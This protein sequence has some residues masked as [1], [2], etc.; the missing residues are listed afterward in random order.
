[1]NYFKDSGNGL[2]FS[3]VDCFN[4]VCADSKLIG[5]GE[6]NAGV[7]VIDGED[8]VGHL[9]SLR[10]RADAA[11]DEND[12]SESE[13][14]PIVVSAPNGDEDSKKSGGKNK[15]KNGSGL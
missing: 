5:R 2:R 14:V 4:R 15:I 6:S 3:A 11:Y 1:V 9:T 7:S 10:N 12:T 13:N 8:G